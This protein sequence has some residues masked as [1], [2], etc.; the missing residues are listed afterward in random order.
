MN[1]KRAVRAVGAGV[2]AV[3]GIV[4]A[5]RALRGD[6]DELPR[7]LPGRQG[8]YR[9]RGMETAY[10]ELGDPANPSLVLVHG[11]NAA[12]SSNEFV[13]VAEALA[14]SYHVFAPDLPGFGRSER[15]A[16]EYSAALYEDYLAA[17]LEDV[18]DDAPVVLASSLSSGYAVAAAKRSPVSRLVLVCPTTETMPGGPRPRV[19]SL[20]RSP[21]LGEALFNLVVSKPSLSRSS[22]DHSYYDPHA[23]DDERRR[24]DWQT[25]HQRGARFAPAAFVAGALDSDVDLAGALRDLDVP[26]TFVWG[27]ESSITPLADGRALAADADAKLVVVDYA[28]LLPHDEHP[29]AFLDAI[30][31][32]LDLDRAVTHEHVDVEQSDLEQ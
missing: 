32:D 20:L 31:A 30:A 8:T 28:K 16:I 23:Y 4:L 19:E 2:T 11:I 21:V 15:A 29:D 26:V 13:A 25:A 24:Y 14:E 18:P 22:A 27:R 3:S 7:P 1:A 6:A 5:N 10:T 17:F 12:A 9:W